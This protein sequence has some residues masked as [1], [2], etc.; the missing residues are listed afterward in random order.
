[1]SNTLAE[2]RDLPRRSSEI[3]ELAIAPL[4]GME[5]REG[6]AFI[7]PIGC[8]VAD[9]L[10]P[11]ALAMRMGRPGDSES[12][13]AAEAIAAGCRNMQVRHLPGVVRMADHDLADELGSALTA[14]GVRIEVV[15]SL[16]AIDDLIAGFMENM[17]EP[18]TLSCLDAPGMTPARLSS[19]AEAAALLFEAGLWRHLANEDLIEIES[20]A[21][22]SEDLRFVSVMGAAGE[23][24]GL[25]FIGDRESFDRLLRQENARGMGDNESLTSLTYVYA[26]DLPAGD[27]EVWS[28]ENLDVADD[29]AYP[30]LVRYPK[31][32]GFERLD[33]ESVAFVEGLCRALANTTEKQIDAGRWKKTVDTPDGKVA[34]TLAI[35][36]LNEAKSGIKPKFNPMMLDP[37]ARDA[38]MLGVEMYMES[39]A[40]ET[41]EQANELMGGLVGR[42]PELP[43]PTT[44][45]E[46][47]QWLCFEAFEHQGRR[48]IQMAR[49]AL[50]ICPDVADAYCILAEQLGF[51][52]EGA[53][54]LYR[55]GMEAGRRALGED[56][57]L[58]DFPFW[59]AVRSRPYMRAREGYARTLVDL[60]RQEEAVEEYQALLKLNPDDNQG[61]RY[62]LEP[63]L[64]E[65]NR[66]DDLEKLFENE[67]YA[68][69]D[70]AAWTYRRALLTF[71][72]EGSGPKATVALSTALKSNAHVPKYLLGR[73]ELPSSQPE[74]YTP[75]DEHEAISVALSLNMM[76]MRVPG[77]LD[78]LAKGKRRVNQG[79]KRKN[80]R[81]RR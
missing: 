34:Y 22:P 33:G 68:D 75:G 53:C 37:R 27:K 2:L 23:V 69:D 8:F 76:W 80:Q 54:E 63:L 11:F 49:E 60:D 62:E 71:R 38:I 14:L 40:P 32:S 74:T 65:L 47:A 6:D 15:Q 78:W 5:F 3:W 70:S 24:Y 18:Q 52:P 42:V 41:I 9:A 36:S 29:D 43:A 57:E 30:V 12:E 16:P 64:M 44:P 67:K 73:A 50:L 59:K 28:D 1:M 26:D 55:Q 45:L 48:R 7:E 19:F 39:R 79:A 35:P 58:P 61:V 72:R 17:V 46:Q 21:P 31:E 20:P 81:K 13:L 51:D 77:A 25:S 10:K 56:F 66:L 4:I